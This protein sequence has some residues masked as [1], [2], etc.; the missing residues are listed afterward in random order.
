MRLNVMVGV[1][2]GPNKFGSVRLDLNGHKYMVKN[3][4]GDRRYYNNNVIL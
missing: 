1:N 3:N 4:R 2:F